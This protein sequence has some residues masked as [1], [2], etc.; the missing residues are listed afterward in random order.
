MFCMYV[1]VLGDLNGTSS[2]YDEVTEMELDL[3]CGCSE[4]EG[5]GTDRGSLS[6]VMSIFITIGLAFAATVVFLAEI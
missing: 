2:D 4:G 6:A 5:Q 3:T 1:F